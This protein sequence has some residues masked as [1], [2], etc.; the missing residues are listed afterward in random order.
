MAEISWSV[1]LEKCSLGGFGDALPELGAN[2]DAS[3]IGAMIQANT[4]PRVIKRR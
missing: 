2:E 1:S 3:V 4:R